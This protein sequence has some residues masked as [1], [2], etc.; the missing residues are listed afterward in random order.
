LLGSTKLG[1]KTLQLHLLNSISNDLAYLGLDNNPGVFLAPN[2]HL[3]VIQKND[4][5]GINV[6]FHSF[7]DCFLVADEMTQAYVLLNVDAGFEEDV[8]KELNNTSG[9]LEV[10]VSYGVYDLIIKVGTESMETLRELITYHLRNINHV[11]STL[12]LILT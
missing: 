5:L 9:V 11:R 2:S 3:Q 12:T 10:Y 8:R 1:F 7:T 6:Y 4:A